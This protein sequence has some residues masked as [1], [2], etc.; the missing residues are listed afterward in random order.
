MWNIEKVCELLGIVKPKKMRKS[1]RHEDLKG[2]AVPSAK[3]VMKEGKKPG[4][5]LLPHESIL[6]CEWC[7]IFMKDNP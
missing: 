1:S 3:L 5:F 2:D 4:K 6:R 7:R